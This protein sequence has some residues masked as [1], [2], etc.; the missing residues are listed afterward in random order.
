MMNS[1]HKQESVYSEA[2]RIV[3]LPRVCNEFANSLTHVLVVVSLQRETL[4]KRVGLSR[5]FVFMLA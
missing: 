3:S 5:F 4:F 2:K 1:I